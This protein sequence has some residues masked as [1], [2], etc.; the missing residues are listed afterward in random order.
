MAN[1]STPINPKYI[2]DEPVEFRPPQG[3]EWSDLVDQQIYPYYPSDGLV[4]AVN[5]A[6]RLNRPLLLEGEPGCGKSQ[7]AAAVAYQFSKRYPDIQWKYRL[8]NIQSTSKAQDG[9]YTYD[10]VGRLQA[11]QLAKVEVTDENMNP[12]NPENFINWGP[13]GY[14]FQEHNC[15]TIVLIDEIDKADKDL[16]N[17]LLL[18]IDQQKFLVKELRTKEGEPCWK[19]ANKAAPPIIFITSNREQE[20]PRAFLRRCLYHYVE[21]PDRKRLTEILNSRFKNLPATIVKPALEKF[22]KLR[23]AMEEDEAYKQVSTSELIDWFQALYDYPPKEIK[24]MLKA[25]IPL[26]SALLKTHQDYN[27]YQDL[28]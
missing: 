4:E 2:K 9:F 28:T 11:A 19:C 1:L 23:E 10:Y 25:G 8:W 17:D 27:R 7:L 15:R 24:E 3:G 18:A 12:S 16:P 26:A 14:A 22:L 21:F 6:I 20:L 13:L 5:L